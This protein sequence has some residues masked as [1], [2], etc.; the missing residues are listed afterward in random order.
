[1]GSINTND[2]WF[3]WSSA[4]YTN[5]NADVQCYGRCA[6]PPVPAHKSAEDL[7]LVAQ[8]Q[9]QCRLTNSP[10]RQP[11]QQVS[12]HWILSKI[13]GSSLTTMFNFDSIKMLL[14][15]SIGR[16]IHLNSSNSINYN[17]SSSNNCNN[18]SS[19]GSSSNSSHKH[20]PR[21]QSLSTQ[22]LLNLQ[23]KRP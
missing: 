3:W 11:Q 7:T 5:P 15:Q 22:G 14:G 13:P 18:S 19:R 21:I 2:I 20:R 17:S 16:T 23:R 9:N 6:A 10:H 1:M 12:F 4:A 8:F